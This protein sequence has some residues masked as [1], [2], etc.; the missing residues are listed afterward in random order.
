MLLG[1]AS[2]LFSANQQKTTTSETVAEGVEAGAE[3]AVVG[4][5]GEGQTLD[6]TDGEITELVY[7]ICTI[8]FLYTVHRLLDAGLQYKSQSLHKLVVLVY[9]RLYIS[10]I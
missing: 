8:C 7:S 1:D 6:V 5:A 10:W 2:S 3:A 4:P 9:D